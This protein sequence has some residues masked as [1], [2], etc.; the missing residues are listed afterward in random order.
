MAQFAALEFLPVG[1]EVLQRKEPFAVT[2][3]D[4][5][6]LAL[7]SVRCYLV[8][9]TDFRGGSDGRRKASWKKYP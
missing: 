9:G 7:Q 5:S 2:V 6:A 8:E 4:P 3:D 1:N